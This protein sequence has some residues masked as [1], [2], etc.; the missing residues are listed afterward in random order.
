MECDASNVAIREVLSQEGRPMD[1]NS[2]KINDAKRKY[3]SY[4][5]ELYALVQDLTK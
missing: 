2:E 4:D 3:S 5:L 1:F